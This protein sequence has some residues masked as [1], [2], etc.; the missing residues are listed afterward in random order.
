M[1]AKSLVTIGI[2]DG[3]NEIGMGKVP[4]EV[5][6]KN[7]PGGNLV[8]CRVATDYNI[9]CGVSNWGGYGLAAGAWNVAGRPFD[10]EL[11]SPSAERDL[12]EKVLQQTTLVDGVTG[13]RTFTVDGLAWDQYI[14]PLHEMGN[15]LGNS[16]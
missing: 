13:Q 14:A 11:F 3:G 15:L 4:W 7:V 12:W 2:G 10:S 8:A 9:V 16:A 6:A 5:I 1:P